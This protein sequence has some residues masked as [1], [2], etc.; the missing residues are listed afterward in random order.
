VLRMYKCIHRQEIISGPV[1]SRAFQLPLPSM[2][3]SETSLS[4]AQY[5][6]YKG[7][8][9]DPDG[10]MICGSIESMAHQ[11]TG[12]CDPVL[13]QINWTI[14]YSHIVTIMTII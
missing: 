7:S 13:L 9:G 14:K 6:F 4:H 12:P 11:G 10:L 3:D 5:I 8:S 2:L 1:L